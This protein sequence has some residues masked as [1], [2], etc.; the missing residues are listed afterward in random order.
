MKC[1]HESSE[2]C[3]I[4]V[5][6][7]VLF[8]IE[9]LV[10]LHNT[11]CSRRLLMVSFVG[12]SENVIGHEK[13]EKKIIKKKLKANRLRFIMIKKQTNWTMDLE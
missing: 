4:T 12:L 1:G 2:I 5:V 8:L 11:D 10:S 7:E 13:L 9:V 6:T 3:W